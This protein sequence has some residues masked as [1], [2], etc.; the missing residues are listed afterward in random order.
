MSM[1]NLNTSN[2]ATPETNGNGNNMASPNEESD[3]E[4]EVGFLHL[5]KSGSYSCDHTHCYSI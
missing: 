2:V 3:V 1:S 4:V 5:S